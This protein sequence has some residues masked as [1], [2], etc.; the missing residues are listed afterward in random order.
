MFQLKYFLKL[1]K[2][3][4]FYDALPQMLITQNIINIL[5]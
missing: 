2:N 4:L 3:I 1:L 5:N